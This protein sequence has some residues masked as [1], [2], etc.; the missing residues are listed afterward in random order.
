L[1][2]MPLLRLSIDG[3][4]DPDLTPIG[5]CTNLTTLI[6]PFKARNIEAL[7]RLPAL[8]RISWGWPG[9]EDKMTDAATFW[10]EYDAQQR[11]ASPK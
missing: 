10:K 6:L 1:R 11:G 9:S 3:T 2:G 5:E 7:R 4:N 8:Q